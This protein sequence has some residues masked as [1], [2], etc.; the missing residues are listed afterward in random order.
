MVKIICIYSITNIVNNKMYVGS[1]VNF[2]RRKRVHLG[3]LRK[4]KHHSIKLQN[5]FNKYGVD[6]FRFDILEVVAST[7]E[8]ISIE[9]KYLDDLKPELNMTLVAGLN[10]HLGM[11]RSDETREKIRKSNTGRSV[12]EE[13]REKIRQYNLGLNKTDDTKDRISIGIK[14]SE[15]YKKS[16]TKELYERIVD[17]K[18]EN[19]SLLVKEETRIKISNTLKLKNES[20]A[21]SKRVGK[22]DLDGNLIKIYDSMRKAE[23]DSKMYNKQLFYY[24]RKNKFD[25][26]I[27]KEFIWKLI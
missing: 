27:I 3:L 1:A 15:K 18:K 23:I 19:G 17:K 16:R 13:T 11:K 26:V 2:N 4:N 20:S 14:S 22:Y 21:I 9:Q 10:S 5:S 6:K 8:L 24:F 12:S 7:Q 25:Q